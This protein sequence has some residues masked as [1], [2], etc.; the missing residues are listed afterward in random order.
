MAVASI[1]QVALIDSSSANF[2][3]VLLVFIAFFFS[4]FYLKYLLIS[5]FPNSF[6]ILL[7]FVIGPCVLPLCL[8]TLEG[9]SLVD[10]LHEPLLTFGS[11]TLFVI[12]SIVAHYAYSKSSFLLMFRRKIYKKLRFYLDPQVK[13]LPSLLIASIGAMALFIQSA[14]GGVFSKLLSAFLPFRNFPLAIFLYIYLK[15]QIC[16]G[17]KPPSRP[18]FISVILIYILSV[19]I[20]ITYNTRMAFIEPLVIVFCIFCFKRLALFI[21]FGKGFLIGLVLIL[22]I[23]IPLLDN[24]SASI[25]LVRAYRS[26]VTPQEIFSM[27]IKSLTQ[28]KPERQIN[29]ANESWWNEQYYRNEFM[30]RFSPIKMIDNTLYIQQRV[31]QSQISQYT[32]IQFIRLVSI[33]PKPLPSFF[34]VTGEQK[35]E[36]NRSSAADIQFGFI[37]DSDTQGRKLTG[38]FISDLYILF[39]PPFS[40]VVYCCVLMIVFPVSDVFVS[41]SQDQKDVLIPS[42][43]G[44]LLGPDHFLLFSNSSVVDMIGYL[45][46]VVE[47]SLAFFFLF[48]IV[49]IVSNI[50][51]RKV[52]AL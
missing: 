35:E 39:G 42:P 28:A 31:S 32:Q 6:L 17:T 5:C 25:T 51:F 30:N 49:S 38:S 19:V 2:S 26:S 48:R 41:Q 45:R 7:G 22:A 36:V 23:A 12:I 1:L 44:I 52:R 50:F 15:K 47:F 43:L 27:T 18:L 29:A 21:P 9:K 34:G 46:L 4:S 40:L 3:A 20:G 10:G 33:L 8:R 13:L 16:L 14:S 24:L 11:I 37:S